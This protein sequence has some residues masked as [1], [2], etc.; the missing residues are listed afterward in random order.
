MTSLKYTNL[1]SETGTVNRKNTYSNYYSIIQAKSIHSSNDTKSK[2][3][4]F[5]ADKNIRRTLS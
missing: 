4:S 1:I 2:T 5:Y 3:A